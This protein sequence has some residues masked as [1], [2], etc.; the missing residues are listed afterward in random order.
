MLCPDREWNDKF[1]EA[2]ERI[3]W[4]VYDWAQSVF[5][6][7]A[8]AFFIPLLLQAMADEH[9]GS[10]LGQCE[11]SCFP[12]NLTNCKMPPDSQ[13]CRT[14]VVGKGYQIVDAYG[15]EKELR[16]LSGADYPKVDF[17]GQQTR[18][19]SFSLV[20][21][22]I[23]VICQALSFITFGAIAD[24]SNFRR[25]CLIITIVVG[26]LASLAFI[27][28]GDP[29][30]YAVAAWLTIVSNTCF[31]LSI[32]FYNAYLPILVQKHPEV[33]AAAPH[34]RQSVYDE[35][36]NYMSTTAYMWGYIASVFYLIVCIV[37]SFVMPSDSRAD[38]MLYYRVT[39]FIGGVW[40]AGFSLWTI[41][42]LKPHP[43]PQLPAGEWLLT[44]GWVS[45]GKTLMSASAFPQTI[46]FLVAYFIYS[47]SYTTVASVG[48]LLMNELLCMSN[49]MLGIVFI[50]VLAVAVFG[51]WL[52]LKVQQ[53]FALQAKHMIFGC[54]C[55]YILLSCLGLLGLIEGSPVGLKN[56]WEAFVF[57]FIHGLCI[58]SIQSFSRVM[59]SDLLIP[60]REAEFFALYEITDRGSSWLGP[61]VMAQVGA[62]TGEYRLGFAYLL[63]MLILPS[64][65]LLTIDHEK[66]MK[67]VRAYADA[68]KVHCV[69]SEESSALRA[70]SAMSN[71][72]MD[73][74]ES[75]G[76]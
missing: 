28:V 2:S 51:N 11:G 37:L 66:G 27:A 22:S 29:S 6:G 49:S 42:Y 68:Q 59:F 62:A 76:L 8:I 55:C 40:W 34:R 17:F 46:K 72:V 60:G 74:S 64:I 54:L 52:T 1:G 43:G 61:M 4:Y 16:D 65:L 71:A 23:S 56:V 19:T 33:K 32:V 21:I 41:K 67:D 18:S 14:C 44:K 20:V 30:L 24:Y 73:S 39:I 15:T 36:Q 3:A 7:V 53:R 5:G 13:S 70:S 12:N 35:I 50:E 75:G 26:C 25:L 63:V 10:K 58:G 9:G 45:T 69:S 31:G 57:G 48:V 38:Q 47:D